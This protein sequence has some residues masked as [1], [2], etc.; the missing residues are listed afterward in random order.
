MLERASVGRAVAGSILGLLLMV[1]PAEA[2]TRVPRGGA[3]VVS[4]SG[5]VGRLRID[6]STPVQIE[7][8]AGRPEY[9]GAGRFRP[10]IREFAPFIAFGYGCKRVRSGGIPT[11]GVDRRSGSPSYSRVVCLTVYWVN[12]RTGRLAGFST[13]S[14]RFHTAAG[15]RPG[16]SLA[17]AKR[18]EHRPTLMDSPSALNVTGRNAVLLIYATI[19]VVKEGDWHVGN[20]VASLALESRR[21]QLG[22][23]FV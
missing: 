23:E 22:L 3:G 20:R 21:H 11:M 4:A 17:A 6:R 10:L 14:R 15:V 8:F 2:G 16:T 9:I 5:V 13:G 7:A 19:V 12:Q 1:T 18:R